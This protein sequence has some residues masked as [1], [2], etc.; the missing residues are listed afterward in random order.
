MGTVGKQEI[1]VCGQTVSIFTTAQV[2]LLTRLRRPPHP[3]PTLKLRG[4]LEPE[5]SP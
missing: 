4:P 2:I 5:S 3:T 1:L